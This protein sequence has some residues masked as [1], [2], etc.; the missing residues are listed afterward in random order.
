ML[1]QRN[2]HPVKISKTFWTLLMRNLAER[3]L[4]YVIISAKVRSTK[5]RTSRR[6]AVASFS[7][8]N[9]S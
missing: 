6:E 5:V 3:K 7:R 4:P 1:S 9:S 8:L 2:P